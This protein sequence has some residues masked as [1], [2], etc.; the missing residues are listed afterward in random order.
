MT[1][2]AQRS[3]RLRIVEPSNPPSTFARATRRWPWLA[4]CQSVRP[5]DLEVTLADR[6]LTVKGTR[7]FDSED[8][9]RVMLGEPTARLLARIR[10][11][12]TLDEQHVTAALADGV[13]DRTNSEAS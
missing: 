1:S 13:V 8:N 6:V 5:E 7:R 11:P 9:E 2:W 12:E 3:E 4:I 10:L